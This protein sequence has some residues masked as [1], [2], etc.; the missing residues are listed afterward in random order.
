MN[1]FRGPTESPAAANET[2]K[3]RYLAL[4]QDGAAIHGVN[5]RYSRWLEQ[6]P[7]VPSE[8][9][10]T[11]PERI[12]TPSKTATDAVVTAV[13]VAALSAAVVALGAR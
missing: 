3:P 12:N 7:S 6:L 9:E 2:F 11:S 5:E 4:L 10:T 1:H 8:E 13:A